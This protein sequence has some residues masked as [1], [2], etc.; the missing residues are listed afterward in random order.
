MT[1]VLDLYFFFGT[2]RKD[3]QTRLLWRCRMVWFGLKI[4]GYKGCRKVFVWNEP[5]QIIGINI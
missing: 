5:L 1:N 3:I 2:G 4:W